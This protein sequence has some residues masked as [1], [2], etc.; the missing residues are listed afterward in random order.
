MVV[1]YFTKAYGYSVCSSTKEIIE[2]IEESLNDDRF[3]IDWDNFVSVDIFYNENGE[4]FIAKINHNEKIV[5]LYDFY[6]LI[7]KN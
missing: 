2:E 6:K 5:E 1:K 4:P 7:N 3:C